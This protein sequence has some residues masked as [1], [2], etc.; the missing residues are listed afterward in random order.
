MTMIVSCHISQ[1]NFP[2]TKVKSLKA[3]LKYL[4]HSSPKEF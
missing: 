2:F 4:K 3:K 1:N